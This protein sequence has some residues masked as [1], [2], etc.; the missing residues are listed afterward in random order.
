MILTYTEHGY[1]EALL[2]LMLSYRKSG[3]E[4]FDLNKA[5][6]VAASLAFR[7]HGHNKFLRQI[8]VWM[9]IKAPVSWWYH[10]DTYKI[11]ITTQSESTMHTLRARSR[12]GLNGESFTSSVSPS[13]IETYNSAIPEDADIDTLR[14]NLPMGFEMTRMVS[15]NYANLREIVRQRKSHKSHHWKQFIDEL[16]TLIKHPEYVIK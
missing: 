15:G 9:T 6:R 16:Q 12:G 5:A 1:E 8:C 7:G 14:D 10:F 11:G 13:V 2:G 3:G 4:Q